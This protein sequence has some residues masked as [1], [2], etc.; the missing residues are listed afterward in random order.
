M[1]VPAIVANGS[2]GIVVEDLYTTLC[3]I[4]STDQS[5]LESGLIMI[6]IYKLKIQIYIYMYNDFQ[7]KY[8]V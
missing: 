2:P 3:T 8:T 1:N 5:D 4:V 7:V 6:W